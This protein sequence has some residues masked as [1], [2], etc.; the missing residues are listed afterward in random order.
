MGRLKDF[1][2]EKGLVLFLRTRLE[3]YGEIQ[4]LSLDSSARKISAVLLLKGE[5]LPVNIV[6]AR[7]HFERKGEEAWIVLE[8]ISVS[9]EW[10]QNLLED[11]VLG[12]QI[13]VPPVV[14]RLLE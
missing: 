13:K 5:T 12:M 6:E 3:R 2:L 1:A 9:R 7:Y 11:H 10:I 4:D 8:S 14:A